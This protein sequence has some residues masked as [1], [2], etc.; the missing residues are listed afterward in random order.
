VRMVSKAASAA[1]LGALLALS[2]C[3]S[4]GTGSTVDGPVILNHPPA[5]RLPAIPACSLTDQVFSVPN[6]SGVERPA[7][8]VTATLKTDAYGVTHIYTDD[9]YALFFANGFVQARDRLFQI[10][11]LR[12]VGYGDSAS[13]IGPAQLGSDAQVRRDLYTR[14]EMQAQLDAMPDELQG[15]LQAYADGVNRFILEATARNAL[16]AEFV[17]LGH[18][19]EPWTPLDS[20]AV[21][22]YLIG[23]F[24]V[25]GGAELG[26]AQRLAQLQSTLGPEKAWK[27]FGDLNWLVADHTYTTIPVADKQVNG[28][29]APPARSAVPAAQMELALAAAGATPAGALTT[30]SGQ[31][32]ADL[33]DGRRS[34]LGI[35]EGFHWG[36]NALLVDGSKTATGQPIMF[37]APQMGYYKPPVPYQIGLHGAGYDAAG[38]GVAGAPGIVIGRNNDIAWSVTSGIDDQVDTIAVR[39]AGAESYLWDGQTKPM[40][41]RDEEH[42]IGPNLADIA[43]GIVT[44]PTTYM[45]RVCRI[46]D[47][48][49]V[50]INEAAG[51]AW[52]QRTT[53]RHEELQGAW[54]WLNVARQSTFDEVRT[55]L[56]TFPFTFNF[57]VAWDGGIGYLHTGNVPLRASSLDPR[58]PA[59][60][61][62]AYA[63]TGESYTAAMDT[64]DT[65]PSS[66][67]YA[68][69][70]NAPVYGW[71]TGDSLQ[72]WGSAHRVQTLDAAVRERLDATGGRLTWEDVRLVNEL[73]ASRD[74]YAA[75]V[76]PH[77]IAAAR[78]DPALADVAHALQSWSDARLPWRD[79][80]GDG[81]Y[82]DPAHAIYDAAL[83]DLM[84]R[85]LGDELGDLAPQLKLDPREA[86]DP[87]AGDH[88]HHDNH[89][90]VVV[91]AL[92]G[93]SAHAWCDD[94]RTPAREGCKQQV[95]ASLR[96]AAADLTASMGP[97]V[98]GW[99]MPIHQS[100][101]TA[102]GGSNPDLI[103]MVNRGSWVQ[104]VAV[105]QGLEGAGS[106]LPPSN[107]GLLTGP[108]L[109]LVL[110]GGLAEPARLT[111][112][113][114]HYVDFSYKPFPLTAA[115]VDAVT[116]TQETLVILP[117]L[118]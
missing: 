3:L 57:H 25:A 4:S 66:G 28:C 90:S 38:F 50:A 30:G 93:R 69:W 21:I 88:G 52:V 99:L 106:V 32:A 112:E 118:P 75:N 86:S 63:W 115:E 94:V 89:Y 53:T 14:D 101:F 49:V 48:P 33:F 100:R 71:R 29:E 65:R 95:L 91:D 60:S 56:A 73:A 24:G 20:V 2:G 1:M 13:V 40:A 55:L 5:G 84:P 70:N 45:Q 77:F 117:P 102:I 72:N 108:E 6:G 85:I 22:D 76:M 41:C 61:G 18:V 11:V 62:A 27:A 51:V 23:Y 15:V 68:N 116:V 12:H 36:S 103:P 64:W 97:D 110:A 19:P 80:N 81:L 10:D 114:N 46:E 111:S 8:P 34:G 9:A 44:P 54:M 113:L 37:G 83:L 105:G 74:S 58:L 67:Y 87:H 109:L 98:S 79:D 39:L 42:R 26:N 78:S 107:T 31:A 35:L 7:T 92:A 104:V 96:K 59:L 16:P 82:D 43:A 47:L 17:A